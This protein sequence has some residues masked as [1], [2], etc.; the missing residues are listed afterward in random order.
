MSKGERRFLLIS[1]LVLFV[2]PSFIL[3]ISL[4]SDWLFFIE[5]G[6]EAVLLK[7]ISYK[8]TS[9][10][11][12]S[13]AFLVFS[14]SNIFVANRLNFPQRDYYTFE[15][16]LQPIKNWAFE[17]LIKPV[18]FIAVI[19]LTLVISQWGAT[20]W[21]QLAIFI[22]GLDM[23]IKDPILQFDIGFYIFSLPFVE[24]LRA[25]VGFTIITTTIMV[26]LNYLFRGGLFITQGFVSIHRGVKIH[27][28]IL[29]GLVVLFISSGFYLE[30]FNLLFKS[31][32]VVSGAGFTDVN[33][34]LPVLTL[35]TFLTP[36][37]GFVCLYGFSKGSVKFMSLPLLIFAA[38]YVGGLMVF[39]NAVQKL[40]VAPN[41]LALET[42]FIENSIKFTRKA[43][44][45]DRIEVIPFDVDYNLKASDIER[46][47]A[48]IKNIR[49]WDHSPLL[50]TY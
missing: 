12:F 42:P 1:F 16:I 31:D 6:Y 39:P 15:N 41:E 48:T 22:N 13:L 45:L 44:D 21:E 33:V 7:T 18:S 32:A 34:R 24:T 11:I 47:E 19:V 46:N 26:F 23:G 43:Y 14:A 35:L 29:L 9:A 8:L 4:Y 36:I 27:L 28:L 3:L 5:T 25:F 20:K 40:K 17:R 38:L 50:R 2:L 10:I 49:L 30:R 37:L